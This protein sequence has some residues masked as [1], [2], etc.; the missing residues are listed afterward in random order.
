MQTQEYEVKVHTLSGKNYK[1]NIQK[2]QT[3]MEELNN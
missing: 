1:Q 2:I 3:A